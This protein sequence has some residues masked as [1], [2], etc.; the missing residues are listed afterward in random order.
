MGQL[1][2]TLREMGLLENAVVVFTSDHGER[3][4]E[5][6]LVPGRIS[7]NGNPSFEEVLQIPLIVAPPRLDDT[8]SLMR[9]QDI[10]SLIARIG[11]VEPE[12]PQ[13]LQPEELYLSEDEYQTYRRGRWKSFVRRSDG[14]SYLVDLVADPKETRDVSRAHPALVEAHRERISVLS[15]ALATA[16]VVRSELTPEYEGRLRA[17]G[18]LE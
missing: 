3:L 2:A 13:D 11:G 4:G 7:H 8:E 15:K 6:H 9:T 10:F 1:L 18:Y 17:L 5:E 12:L 14:A 16:R